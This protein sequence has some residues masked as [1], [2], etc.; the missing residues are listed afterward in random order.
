[1]LGIDFHQ[2]ALDGSVTLEPVYCLGLCS[3]SPSAMLDGE[4]IGRLDAALSTRSCRGGTP[5]TVRHLRSPAI[6]PLALGA[7]R[8]AKAIEAELKARGK[9]ARIVRNGS[10]GAY[11]LARADGRSGRTR[12][13]SPTAR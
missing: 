2:T 10:R 1:L 9:E 3:C 8:V 6:P 5:M 11:A 13:A 4:V 12:A 7:D